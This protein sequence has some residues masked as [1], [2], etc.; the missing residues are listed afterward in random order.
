M[1]TGRRAAALLLCAVSVG[2]HAAEPL[3]LGDLARAFAASRAMERGEAEAATP[4]YR[5]GRFDGYLIGI[6]EVLAARGE[7]CL[8]ACFC[9]VREHLDPAI[10]VALA[11]PQLDL[12]QPAM[13]WLAGELRRRYPCRPDEAARR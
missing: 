5:A 7:I 13:T 2:G 12:A 8:P 6:A 11:D 3:R 4:A 1:S 10:E 9:Q